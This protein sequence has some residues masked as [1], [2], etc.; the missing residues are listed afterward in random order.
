MGTKA[1]AGQVHETAG[2]PFDFGVQNVF[3][4]YFEH[5]LGG[6]NIEPTM[7]NRLPSLGGRDDKDNIAGQGRSLN[8]GAT[9]RF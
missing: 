4:T 7:G 5:P 3:D 8:V 2:W 1:D 6:I 9:Y